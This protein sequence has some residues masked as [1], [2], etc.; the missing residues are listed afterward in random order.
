MGHRVLLV[1]DDASFALQLASLLQFHGHEVL[2]AWD[3]EAA[4]EEF[5]DEDPDLVL[6]EMM[7]PDATGPGLIEAIRGLPGGHDVPVLLMS[8]TYHSGRLFNEDNQRLGVLAFLHKPFSLTDLA[9]RVDRILGA[10]EAGRQRVRQMIAAAPP[11]RTGPDA[12]PTASSVG[13]GG[14]AEVTLDSLGIGRRRAR[15]QTEPESTLPQ[16]TAEVVLDLGQ[17]ATSLPPRG[18]PAPPP[19]ELR[20]ARN[21]PRRRLDPVGYVEVLADLFHTGDSG[22]LRLKSDQATWKL[23]V[24]NGYP[25]WADVD[26]PVFGCSDYLLRQGRITE[27]QSHQIAEKQVKLGWSAQRVLLA[28]QLLTVQEMDRLL[29][30]WVD[31][32]VTRGLSI[33][34]EM[35][36][37][38]GD[39]FA[40]EIPVYEVNPISAIWAGVQ[41]TIR[42][43]AAEIGLVKAEDRYLTRRRTHDRLFGYVAT[44]PV[45]LE[46]RDWLGESRQ[47]DAIRDYFSTSW[48]EVAR[49]LWLLVHAGVVRV[50]EEPT[51]DT[52]A[53]LGAIEMV[54]GADDEAAQTM[55]FDRATVDALL[56]A[57]PHD[58]DAPDLDDPEVRIIHDYVS[59]M[60]QDHYAFLGIAPDADTAD[61]DRAYERLAPAYRPAKLGARIQGDT[62]RKAKELLSRL[63]RAWSVLSDPVQREAYDEEIGRDTDWFDDGVEGEE[64]GEFV[65]E[66]DEEPVDFEW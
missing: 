61:I 60:D 33:R 41:R 53:S 45:L 48:E 39:R 1:E 10:P 46:L 38:G 30:G 21:L 7:L 12:P 52:L 34:G 24:L 9:R 11:K 56:A 62:R 50:S 17:P 65:M 20:P 36:F 59:K 22:V 40:S 57:G 23:Y 19:H 18:I 27:A 3:G 8:Q 16:Q 5:A 15:P 66:V 26:P 63:V 28:M 43:G 14:T 2:Q 54:M 25:V 55:R 13:A 58:V 6:A 35:E 31:H 64:S 49:A 47:Y 51:E 44:T 29:Q 42:L 32:E 4:I 37:R